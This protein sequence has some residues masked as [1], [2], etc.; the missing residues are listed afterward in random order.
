VLLAQRPRACGFHL[1]AGK[2]APEDVVLAAGIDADHRP[3][4]MIV[5]HDGHPWTPDHVQD[6]QIVRAIELLDPGTL[7][8]A[9]APENMGRLRN[10]PGNDLADR[11]VRAVLGYGSAAVGDEL[12]HVEHGLTLR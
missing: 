9:P 11:F 1:A 4:L 3:H 10:R 7:R 8:L 6:R 12:I 5:R 2:P